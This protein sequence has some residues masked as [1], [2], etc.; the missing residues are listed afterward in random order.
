MSK[1]VS[2]RQIQVLIKWKVALHK[3]GVPTLDRQIRE[4]HSVMKEAA[5]WDSS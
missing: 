2:L 3:R 1:G 4:R 5:P